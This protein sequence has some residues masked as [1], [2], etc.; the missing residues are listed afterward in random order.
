M[1]WSVTEVDFGRCGPSQTLVGSQVGVVVKPEIEPTYE[2]SFGQGLERTQ[3]QGVFE[4]SPE[5]FDDRN[6]WSRGDQ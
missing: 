5:S 4:G 1:S 2:V 3:A 6:G